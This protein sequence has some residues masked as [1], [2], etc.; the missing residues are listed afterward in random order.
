M[1][2]R[3]GPINYLDFMRCFELEPPAIDQGLIGAKNYQVS[4]RPENIARAKNAMSDL[5][6]TVF[7]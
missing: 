2:G 6:A 1:I 7:I 5:L 3:S 4:R